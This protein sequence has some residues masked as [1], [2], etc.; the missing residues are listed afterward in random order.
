MTLV[1]DTSVLVELERGN[2]DIQKRVR[3]LVKLHAGH[4]A[5]AFATFA[6]FYYGTLKRNPKHAEG[7]LD[8]LEAYKVLSATRE[9]ARIFAELKLEMEQKGASVALFD[10]LI[11]SLTL[12]YDGVLVTKDR[13]F[14]RIPGLKVVE[15]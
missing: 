15:I 9:S 3:R 4:P 10:L 13:G 6:E 11:A 12:Q 7:M 5:I 8:Y 2:T 1:F 14:S